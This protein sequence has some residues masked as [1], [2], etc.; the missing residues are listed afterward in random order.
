MVK[1]ICSVKQNLNMWDRN[2]KLDLSTIASVSCSNMLMVKD[3]ELQDA[4]HEYI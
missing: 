1:I 3:W 4:Q 2:I